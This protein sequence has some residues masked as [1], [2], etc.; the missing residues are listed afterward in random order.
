MSDEPKQ[1]KAARRC[2]AR[3]RTRGGAPCRSP[4]VRGRP[5]CR[6][7]GC[8]PGSGG[9]RGERSGKFKHGRSTRE[10]K[11]VSAFFREMAKGGEELLAVTLDR[12]GLGRKIPAQLRRRRHV[13]KARAAAAKAKG[14]QQ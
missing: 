1:L 13:K 14:D 11:Q 12:A 2:G 7:H 4:A 10:A 8:A 9:P 6:M 5:R 3:A